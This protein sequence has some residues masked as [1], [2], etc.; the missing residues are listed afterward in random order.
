M[1]IELEGF[2]FLFLGGK[3]ASSCNIEMHAKEL[4][5]KQGASWLGTSGYWQVERENAPDA[6]DSLI[7]KLI[8]Y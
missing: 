4:G 1:E 8:L 5:R 6:I 7:I 2:S 3:E